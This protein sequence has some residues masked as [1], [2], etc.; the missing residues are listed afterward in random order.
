MENLTLTYRGPETSTIKSGDVLRLKPFNHPINYTCLLWGETYLIK[1]GQSEMIRKIFPGDHE[2]EINIQAV[3]T[4]STSE[5]LKT[6][7][8][9]ELYMVICCVGFT[10]K[11]KYI[12]L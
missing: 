10:P 1:T 2:G 3:E 7:D 12:E 5:G 11:L 6:T 4:G 8:I 9:Q